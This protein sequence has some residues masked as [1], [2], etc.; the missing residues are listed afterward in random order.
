LAVEADA[1]SDVVLVHQLD[2]GFQLVRRAVELF[3]KVRVHIDDREF[4]PHKQ[5]LFNLEHWSRPKVLQQQVAAVATIKRLLG[6]CFQE[7]TSK[8]EETT[9]T[10]RPPRDKTEAGKSCASHTRDAR[11][12][13]SF[14]PLWL[15]LLR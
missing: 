15:T 11:P 9:K 1:N 12:F 6:D 3:A 4:R 5:M 7:E 14:V 2:P 13:A 10:R 8:K